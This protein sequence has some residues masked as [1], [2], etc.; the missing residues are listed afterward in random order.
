MEP[1]DAFVRGARPAEE[2]VPPL[3]YPGVGRM[4]TDDGQRE[5][6]MTLHPAG[7]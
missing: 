3:H 6:V 7:N 1:P 5:A 2:G 4:I